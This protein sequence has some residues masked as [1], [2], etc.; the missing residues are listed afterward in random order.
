MKPARSI[1]GN[2][3]FY[4]L[5]AIF[6]LGLLIALLRGS[7]QE[8]TGIDS[9]RTA[10]QVSEV[11]RHAAEIA[12]GVGFILQNNYGEADI[13][14]AR[15]DIIG[16]YG[17]IASDPRRQIFHQTG[18]GVEY[19]LPP[20]GANDG[21]PWQFFATTHIQDIGTDTAAQ[22]RA[23]LLAVLPNVTQ[24]F[25]ARANMMIGQA[26]DLAVNTDPAANGCVHAPGS[27][28]TGTFI[29]GSST[30]S[31]TAAQI[32]THPARE[33]CVRCN[34]GTFHYYRV[35]LER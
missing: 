26:V 31:L 30:N 10:L 24:A 22:S 35:L 12:R 1:A 27:E 13:R 18:G 6:L 28:F 2:I 17:D 4:L 14:F 25:C 29:N 20:T 21:T 9:D 5:A 23:E 16:A 11:Q 19:R 3:L 33:L 34:G 15:P 32:P 7:F 8:G